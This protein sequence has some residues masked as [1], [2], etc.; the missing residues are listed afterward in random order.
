VV[1]AS[2]VTLSNVP[3][4]QPVINRGSPPLGWLADLGN[5]AAKQGTPFVAGQ[6]PGQVQA[7]AEPAPNA[8]GW[9]VDQPDAGTDQKCLRIFKTGLGK[10]VDHIACQSPTLQSDL[11]QLRKGKI[12]WTI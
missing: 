1:D 4:N 5:K 3:P 8:F 10:D 2:G 6:S 9:G 7:A 11:E 12:K